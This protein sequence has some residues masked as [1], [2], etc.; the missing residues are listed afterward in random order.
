M[1]I[2]GLF[3]GGQISVDETIAV[4]HV[5][6]MPIGGLTLAEEQRRHEAAMQPPRAQRREPMPLLRN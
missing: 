5:P 2:W 4:E 3:S 1:A 6:P